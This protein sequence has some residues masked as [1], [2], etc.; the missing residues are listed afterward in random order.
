MVDRIEEF[1]QNMELHMKGIDSTIRLQM[2][3]IDGL[4]ETYNNL[5]KEIIGFRD[6]KE[7]KSETAIEHI[8][9][10]NDTTGCDAIQKNGIRCGKNV[11]DGG[12]FCKIH[13][14]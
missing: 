2:K 4:R 1:L 9:E 6:K 12:R 13:R 7:K 11:S 14:K 3:V 8:V 10:E 5:L